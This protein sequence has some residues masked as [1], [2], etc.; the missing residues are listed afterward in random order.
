MIRLRK[1]DLLLGIFGGSCG[2][3]A[4]CAF[5]YQAVAALPEQQKAGQSHEFDPTPPTVFF[6]IRAYRVSNEKAISLCANFADVMHK[7]EVP[8][9][10]DKAQ[11]EASIQEASKQKTLKLYSSP[12]IKTLVEMPAMSSFGNGKEQYTVRGLANMLDGRVNY[13]FMASNLVFKTGDQTNPFWSAEHDGPFILKS[14]QEV[15]IFNHGI[16]GNPGVITI[17]EASFNSSDTI[18]P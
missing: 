16:N 5:P 1:S 2:L 6:R 7:S 4:L 10:V 15:A 13:R 8:V 17:F 14:G 11:F 18:K 12:N 3:L 9:L